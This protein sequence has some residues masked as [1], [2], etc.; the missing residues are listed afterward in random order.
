MHGFPL[1]PQPLRATLGVRARVFDEATKEI[2]DQRQN[3]LHAPLDFEP[4]PDK[5]S[6]D[7]YHPSE[8]SYI[9]FGRGMADALIAARSG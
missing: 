4:E 2:A 3:V 1:L 5:F 9:E 7:G 6:A 8:E